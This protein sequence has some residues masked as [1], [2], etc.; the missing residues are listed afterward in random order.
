MQASSYLLLQNVALSL[1]SGVQSQD[2]LHFK[3]VRKPTKHGK[4]DE[5]YSM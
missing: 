3:T 2:P 4:N 1:P 5:S